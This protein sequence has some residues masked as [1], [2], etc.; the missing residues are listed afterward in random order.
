MIFPCKNCEK[1][2]PNCHSS[3]DE[4]L[5][6]KEEYDRCK[7]RII[8]ESWYYHDYNKRLYYKTNKGGHYDDF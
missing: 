3:C 2:H 1:R 5:K 4:Y 6:A 8:P 7:R